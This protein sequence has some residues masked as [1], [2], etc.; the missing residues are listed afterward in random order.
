MRKAQ[1]KIALEFIRILYEA[2]EQ[3]RNMVERKEMASA[4]ELL[5]QCQEGAI[6]LGGFIEQIEGENFSG[7][8]LIE[9]Y[10]ETIYQ[11]HEDI[12]V[13][14]DKSGKKAYKLLQKQLIQIENSIKYDIKQKIEIVFFPYSAS[15]WD[16][17][18][19]I[20]MAANE[21]ENCN[22]IVVPI[23][24]FEKNSDGSFGI[25]HY[26]GNKF[27]DYVPIVPWEQY[28]LEKE[29]PEAVY[30]HNPF[31]DYN[32]VTSV[33]PQY[34]S[35]NIKL[36]TDCLVYVPYYSTS[37]GM[38]EGQRFC[39][40]YMVVDYIVI[41]APQFRNYYAASIPN[42]KFLPL[43]SPK[44]DRIIRKCQNPQ[45][46]Q[47]KWKEKIEGK[48][49]YFYNTSISGMLENTPSFLQKIE[50]VFNC[51]K[52]I[53]NAC[54]MWRP[55][56]LLEST[57]DS[58][59]PHLKPH[60][61][62]L[63][64]R[65]IDENLGI[66]DT[67]PDVTNTIALCDAYVGDAGTSITSLFGI[68]GKPMFILNN[69]IHSDP[70]EDDW[71][72][73]II[74]GFNALNEDDRWMVT[75]GNKLYYSEPGAY[76]FHYCCSL[77]EFSAGTY[78]L[79]VRNF[80]EK[81]YVCPVNAQN[82]LLIE[83][84]KIAKK[85]E[86]ER[87]VD[88]GP[89]FA[90]ALKYEQYIFL[91]PANYGAIVRYNTVTEEIKYF[92]ENVEIFV[93]KM[94]QGLKAG[95]SCVYKSFLVVAS[96]VDDLVYILN[97]Q[98]EEIQIKKIGGNNKSGSSKLVADN[99][100]I[101]IIPQ[102]GGIVKRWNLMTG[103]LMEFDVFPGELKCIQPFQ[104]YECT[105][106]P[107]GYPAIT[108][109]AVYLPPSW[110][111]L[112]IKIDKKNGQI[113]KWK[114]EFKVNTVNEYYL[115]A[116]GCHYIRPS[117]DNNQ[118]YRMFSVTDRMLF[119]VNLD[120]GECTN[121]EVKFD[122]K[123]LENHESGFSKCDEWLQ[124]CCRENALNSLNHFLTDS[125]VGN[126]FSKKEQIQAYETVASNPDGSCGEKVHEY[127]VKHLRRGIL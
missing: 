41:Q 9:D 99:D 78:Y 83:N 70:K 96:P 45:V 87:R 82:I 38:S 117:V 50:Y 110:G 106:Y 24:Y 120:T 76:D 54:L 25:M 1:K 8:R 113:K 75:Q 107:F 89:V 64:R 40:S 77:S 105:D 31:D 6:Q 53:E 103:D 28:N 21:D 34:Y 98:T 43:G 127:V 72:G 27:P 81:A 91:I 37:G 101:W 42:E 66:Y 36:H 65:F 33:H 48:K 49:V 104:K 126:K 112:Y 90:D 16:S 102:N 95:G 59:R 71:R 26:D 2:H 124:Y 86:L 68:A 108:E 46:T 100:D 57:F 39:P 15:M 123:E 10:C 88:K 109:D 116:C 44:F 23:P 35:R 18:E 30:I 17:L 69:Y 63:K 29:H 14:R 118:F 32:Y 7:I 125:C 12:G 73:E 85:I 97:L 114:P 74:T 61:D 94:E 47:E 3:I 119:D 56:P 11:I 80:G 122:I 93:R 67:T 79:T 111:N 121:I 52:S 13:N 19:S 115:P 22:P 92:T 51:F 60:Y 84:K 20:W 5:E 58:M 55:H 62:A 4:M